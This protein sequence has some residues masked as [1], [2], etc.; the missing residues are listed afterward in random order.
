VSPTSVTSGLRSQDKVAVVFGADGQVGARV[1][2][3]LARQGALLYVSGPGVP[4]P[5]RACGLRAL[6]RQGGDAAEA[7]E[8]RG[9]RRA[10]G[11]PADKMPEMVTSRALLGGS[12]TS[13]KR[14]GL[15]RSSHPTKPPRSPGAIVNSPCGQ[16]LD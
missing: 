10:T 6:D 15:S 2:D 4:V 8:R 11:A 13:P 12:P 16:V 7:A 14:H 3:E 1:A 5:R 9:R